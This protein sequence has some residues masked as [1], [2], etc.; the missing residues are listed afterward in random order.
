VTTHDRPIADLA[1]RQH[2]IFTRQQAFAVGL[3]KKQIDHRVQTAQWI[4][5]APGLYALPG[6][7]ATW[8]RQVMAAVLAEPR[9]VAS[10]GTAAVLH[11]FQDF[12]R[13]HPE[14]TVPSHAN[15]RSP[16]ARVRRSDLVAATVVN[17]IPVTTV[18][19]TVV[20]LSARLSAIRLGQIVDDLTTS[21]RTTIPRLSTRLLQLES[22]NR[23]GLV[24]LRGVV[25]TRSDDAWVPPSS[26]LE[27]A[28]YGLLG[29][30][31]IPGFRRQPRF[32]WSSGDSRLLDSL[33]DD[34]RIIVEGDG[35]RWHT[36][37]A[38]FE[39]DRRRD[40]EA[41]AHG[42]LPIRLGWEE[43]MI[44]PSYSLATILAVGAQRTSGTA[45]S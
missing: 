11:E 38:D 14:I 41:L 36:R 18:E 27:E 26:V 32:P 1:R 33:I 21:R 40:H 5:I 25:S 34:W 22:T 2:G 43:L 35:R 30:P 15:H 8:E 20:D 19:Q 28:L 45:T 37:V 13:G 4:R 23:A 24:R 16:L 17:R 31:R 10:G 39:R 3:S 42:Y 9:A 7:P 29:D 12:R 6:N 44:D